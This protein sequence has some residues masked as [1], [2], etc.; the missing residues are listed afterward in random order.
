MYEHESDRPQIGISSCLLGD[1]VRFDGGHKRSPFC[2]NN[3]ADYVDYV[4]VCPEMAIGMG[5]P[6]PSIR[7]VKKQQND[8]LS[9]RIISAEGE[10]F[11]DRMKSFSHQQAAKL[12]H[13]SGYIV[14]AKSPTCGMERVKVYNENGYGSK[15]G[16]GVYTR[17]LQQHH[18]LLPI[19]EQG[20]L[21]DPLLKENFLT[22]VYAYFQWLKVNSLGLDKQTLITF[23]S[24]NKYLLMAHN[25]MAY[26]SCGRLLADLSKDFDSVAEQYI[27]QFMMGL[28]KPANRKGHAYVL[29]HLQGYFKKALSKRQRQELKTVIEQYRKGT[30]PLLAPLTLLNHYQ[31]EHPSDYVGQQSYFAPHPESLSLRYA[32]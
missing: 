1:T 12:G 8:H 31:N 7:L 2:T 32:I 20:R 4:K 29:Q 6:R 27:A 16:M 24:Q 17:I 10:D 30:L 22:R 26:K 13:L 9:I 23:H 28:A 18:P 14:C 15:D 21:N 5:S 19:E 11:T 3:L 25:V